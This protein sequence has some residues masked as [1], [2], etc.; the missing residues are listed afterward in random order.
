MSA[1]MTRAQQAEDAEC[2]AERAHLYD[3]SPPA[4]RPWPCSGCGEAFRAGEMLWTE[5]AG[6]DY[7]LCPGCMGAA[8]GAGRVVDGR[9]LGELERE[10]ESATGVSMDTLVSRHRR[11]VPVATGA[12]LAADARHAARVLRGARRTAGIER[13]AMATGNGDPVRMRAADDAVLAAE[14]ELLA[15]VYHD[16]GLA[17]QLMAEVAR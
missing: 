15:A 3:A 8:A 7:R 12:E 11:T 1:S 10:Y 2:R 16:R 13:Y 14:D 4:L 5:R 9:S 6:G 17:R